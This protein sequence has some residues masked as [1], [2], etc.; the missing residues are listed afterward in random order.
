VLF[1]SAASPGQ[2]GEE[3]VSLENLL[4]DDSMDLLGG[5]DAEGEE[6]GGGEDAADESSW[7][8]ALTPVPLSPDAMGREGLDEALGLAERD[9]DEGE[10]EEDEAIDPG[11][12]KGKIRLTKSGMMRAAKIGKRIGKIMLKRADRASGWSENWRTYLTIAAA[13]ILTICSGLWIGCY[14]DY[15]GK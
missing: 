8:D 13:I 5:D 12:L 9:D 2:S 3:E 15:T 6:E 1:R 10:G 7:S 11:T 4:P 14:F